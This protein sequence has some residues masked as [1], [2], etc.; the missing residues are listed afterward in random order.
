MAVAKHGE[1]PSSIANAIGSQVLNINLGIGLP[2]LL[3][4]VIRGEPVQL[5]SSSDSGHLIFSTVILFLALVLLEHVTLKMRD[6]V[7]LL[8]TY[9]AVI[10]GFGVY[11]HHS[12]NAP[13]NGN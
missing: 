12:A 2:F 7:F 13:L 10:V 8:L 6:A 11:S 4:N 5:M 1:G 3:S 9:A